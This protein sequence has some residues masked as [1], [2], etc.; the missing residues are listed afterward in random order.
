M[1][2]H[3]VLKFDIGNEKDLQELGANVRLF[4]VKYVEIMRLRAGITSESIS[5]LSQS[6]DTSDRGAL[7]RQAAEELLSDEL[8]TD[9]RFT[10]AGKRWR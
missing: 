8:V 1:K 6:F 3:T 7:I 4:I 2:N 9:V 10:S 5:N